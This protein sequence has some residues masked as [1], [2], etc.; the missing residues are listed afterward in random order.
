[1]KEEEK[2]KK[3]TKKT[4]KKE[5]KKATVKKE[6]K[7]EVK[8]VEKKTASK[9]EVKKVEKKATPKKETKK[10]EKKEP[11]KKTTAKKETTKKVAT[12]KET[13]KKTATK[14]AAPKTSKKE[15]V[16]NRFLLSGEAWAN[17]EA[18]KDEI[19]K[20]QL[21]DRIYD[22]VFDYYCGKPFRGGSLEFDSSWENS[23][24]PE[25]LDVFEAAKR[26]GLQLKENERL[27]AEVKSNLIN[28]GRMP[29]QVIINETDLIHEVAEV[30]HN[31]WV[32]EE[33]KEFYERARVAKGNITLGVQ[34][35]SQEIENIIFAACY[36]KGKKRNDIGFDKNRLV[37]NTD[38]LVQ[39]LDD[40]SSFRTLV[41][42]NPEYVI[43]VKKYAK[44]NIPDNEKQADFKHSTGEE[45]ILR[46]FSELS[47]ISK[48][49][50]VA[51]ALDAFTAYKE[52]TE[53]GV[54]LDTLKNDKGIRETALKAMNVSAM[55]NDPEYRI[56]FSELT[57]DEKEK[58]LFALD[59]L[60]GVVEN[61]REYSLYP[62]VNAVIPDYDKIENDIIEGIKPVDKVQNKQ[63]MTAYEAEQVIKK[64]EEGI[65][66][67]GEEPIEKP[68]QKVMGY[69][70]VWM[71]AISTAALTS[72][73]FALAA[74]YFK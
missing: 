73:I 37:E 31:A 74:F 33:I 47:S 34:N 23:D 42:N 25:I 28:E 29:Q 62:V 54:S 27:N 18:N 45:N 1:M 58:D 59:K 51:A 41:G 38:A 49:G 11:T 21:L 61:S 52:L 14:K 15:E 26:D 56:R 60:I 63:G 24:D 68:S 12:K 17:I 43:D 40:Y 32:E 4:E 20:K 66:V 39:S 10:V 2:K 13:E 35:V 16:T 9:K 69:A 22:T 65:D 55:K 48:R 72:A 67:Y 70:G 50:N 64:L 71:V 3:T 5:T 36:K 8:K 53:A 7:K 57:D 6:T 30:L 46:P 19:E 44:R